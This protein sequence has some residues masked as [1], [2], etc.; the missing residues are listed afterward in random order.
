MP[1][2]EPERLRALREYR[3]LDTPADPVFD[4]IAKLAAH[5]CRVPIAVISLVDE[6]RQWFKAK[7]G[8]RQC[9]TPRNIAF[10]AHTILQ[11]GPMIIRDAR[12]DRRFS[13][14]PLVRRAPHIRFYAGFPLIDHNGY[15][16]GSLCAIDRR[17]RTL[18]KEQVEAM[19]R[20]AQ[21][22]IVSMELRRL[23]HRLATALEHVKTL[24]SLIPICAW[25]HRIRDDQGYWNRLESYLHEHTEAD[26]THSICPECANKERRRLGLGVIRIRNATGSKGG[27]ER[28]RKRASPATPA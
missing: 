8:T 11:E 14:S 13:G 26:F 7:V 6:S 2:N 15:R 23:S 20:L 10:C 4:E 18:T 22:V 28:F 21:L 1:G 24:S 25:C 16:L 27:A 12:K 3:I 9:G 19:R 5:V 17:P